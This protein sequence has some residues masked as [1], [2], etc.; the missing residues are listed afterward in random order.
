MRVHHGY[1]RA[2]YP[3]GLQNDVAE[4]TRQNC[5]ERSTD[6]R[7]VAVS[8]QPKQPV[9]YH[10]ELLLLEPP[11]LF[12][13]RPAPDIRVTLGIR[14]KGKPLSLD[15]RGGQICPPVQRLFHSP[16]I[17][18]LLGAIL[19]EGYDT[20]QVEAIG[21]GDGCLSLIRGLEQLTLRHGGWG[22]GSELL[23]VEGV[24]RKIHPIRSTGVGPLDTPGS[25]C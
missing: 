22:G 13:G 5:Y 15:R 10:S 17:N 19:T 16:L 25:V 24:S 14:D 1:D 12:V 11:F 2:T 8:C 20:V 23:P 9:A 6:S 4:S 3:G 7:R 21:T 18:S